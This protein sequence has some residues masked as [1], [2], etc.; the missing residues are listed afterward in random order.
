[1]MNGAYTRSGPSNLFSTRR[2]ILGLSIT[3]AGRAASLASRATDKEPL[4]CHGLRY[5][6]RRDDCTAEDSYD[7]EPDSSLIV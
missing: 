5:D 7:S 1:M 6:G 4:W 2:C 3:I